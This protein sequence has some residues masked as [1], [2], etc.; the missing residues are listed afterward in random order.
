MDRIEAQARE[1]YA[2][3]PQSGFYEV[4]KAN[5]HAKSLREYDNSLVVL[6]GAHALLDVAIKKN[7]YLA[8]AYLLR[9]RLLITEQQAAKSLERSISLRRS[10]TSSRLPRQGPDLAR[11]LEYAATRT[12]S[13]ATLKPRPIRR[14]GR[15]ASTG[16]P[17]PTSSMRD[18]RSSSASRM[19]QSRSHRRAKL[20]GPLSRSACGTLASPTPLLVSSTGWG[21]TS[22]R[23]HWPHGRRWRWK[24][25][26]ARHELAAARYRTSPG[27]TSAATRR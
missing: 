24:M 6:K 27:C 1:F 5:I 9:A 21:A 16:S 15:R 8:Q 23:R 14:G 17:A 26:Y 2:T 25:M 11:S 19:R 10:S 20:I 4:I 12:T 13:S 18:A 22:H 7:P 3:L